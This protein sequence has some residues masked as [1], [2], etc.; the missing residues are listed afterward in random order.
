MGHRVLYNTAR[1]RYTVTVVRCVLK[2]DNTSHVRYKSKWSVTYWNT[3][4]QHRYGKKVKESAAYWNTTIHNIYGIKVKWSVTY[5]N[6]T[7]WPVTYGN[8][9]I[10]HRYDTKHVVRYV[11]EYDNTLD[12]AF[13]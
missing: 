11:L 5:Q 4:I 6:T 3:T 8:T 2:H 12:T 9:T 1:V 13:K 10:Q 7:N